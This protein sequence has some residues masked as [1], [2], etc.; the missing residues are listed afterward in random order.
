MAGWVR[1]GEPPITVRLR[2][3]A[4]A[5]RLVL[6]VAAEGEPVLTAPVRCRP[7]ELRCFLDTH[8]SWLRARLAARPAP[9]PLGE[10]A[11]L[12]VGGREVVLQ[13]GPRVALR[14]DG[15]LELPGP[16]PLLPGRAAGF[17]RVLARE[18]CAAAASR[19]AAALGRAHGRITLRDTRSRWGSCTSRG[20]LMFSW[21]LAMAP[22]EVLDYVV[23]HEVAH[24]AEMNH[25]E[26]FWAVVA[27]LMPGYATPR[28][29]LRRNGAALH[30]YDF[31]T[32]PAERLHPA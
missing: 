7:A 13:L 11:R 15:V 10:G 6:R 18:A 3:Q 23:A 1:I 28:A 2:R 8:E 32:L 21:R 27:R 9:V 17:L 5:R 22:P 12:P 25:S 30:R 16:E 29:W 19:H 4:N 14:D 24:L 31:R 26:R 20:D